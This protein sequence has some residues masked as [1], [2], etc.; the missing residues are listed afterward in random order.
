MTDQRRPVSFEDAARPALVC[1][2]DETRERP[3]TAALEELGYAVEVA[4]NPEE[5]L[6]RI[7]KTGYT[8]VVVDEQFAGATALDNPVL[9]AFA[10]MS[11]AVRR[12]M[13][14]LLIAPEAVT[15]DHATAFARSVNAIV[16][17]NDLGQLMPIIRRAVADNDAFY[18]VFREVLIA[19]GK[20]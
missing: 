4:L 6:E 13:F 12:Y 9:S 1:V 5:A 17:Y 2:D 20:R 3:V 19:A 16:S 18:R 8:V 14:V 10:A 7:R 15:L 11:M